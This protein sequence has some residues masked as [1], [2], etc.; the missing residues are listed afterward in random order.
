MFVPVCNHGLVM[1]PFSASLFA[2]ETG[3]GL[4]IPI[5]YDNPKFP[6]DFDLVKTEFTKQE[7]NYKFLDIKESL[8]V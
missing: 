3:A 4:V 1:D 7:L 2:R 6:A 8:D 5:H